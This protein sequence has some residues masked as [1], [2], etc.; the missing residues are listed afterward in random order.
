MKVMNA[1]KIVI[2]FLTNI[3]KYW[4]KDMKG[5][6]KIKFLKIQKI[7]K[8]LQLSNDLIEIIYFIELWDMILM[9]YEF[10]YFVKYFYLIINVFNII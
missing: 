9:L 4:L 3:E 10:K 7:A 1:K 6:I 2:K 5:K 8:I